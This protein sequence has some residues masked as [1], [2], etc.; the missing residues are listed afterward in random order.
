MLFYDYPGYHKINLAAMAGALI[1]PSLYVLSR[2]RRDRSVLLFFLGT[3]LSAAVQIGSNTRVRA[4]TGMML[5]ATMA[6]CLYLFS[7]IGEVMRS[8]PVFWRRIR[9]ASAAAFAALVLL[10]LGLRIGSVYRDAGLRE[11][12]TK[13]ENGPGSG[14][15]TTADH[16]RDYEKIC[17]AVSRAAEGKGTLLVTNLLPFGYLLS[18]R[19]PATPSTYNMTLDTEWLQAYY[20][21]H[22]DRMPDVVFCVAERFGVSNDIALQGEAQFLGRTGYRETVIPEGRVLEKASEPGAAP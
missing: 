7:W 19:V 1:C 3:A 11:L 18:E 4:S 16:A 17:S 15:V 2:G 14:L 10:I 20:S 12:N 21:L 5:P 8:D 9:R 13:L 6:G 22:P